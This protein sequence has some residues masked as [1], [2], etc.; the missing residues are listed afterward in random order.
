M[1]VGLYTSFDRLK[2]MWARLRRACRVSDAG[3]AEL[4]GGVNILEHY[5]TSAPDPQNALDIFAG[6]WSSKFPEPLADLRA[7]SALLFAD[8]RIEWSL[9]Q[10]GGVQGKT[11]LELG[12][13]EGGHTYMLE[14]RG[15]ASIVAIEANR[16]AY[17]KCLIVKELLDLRRARFLCG[18]FVEYLRSNSTRFDVCVASGILY[19]LRNPVELI[20]LAE[21]ASDRLYIWTH[22]YDRTLISS[23]P[24]L[25]YKFTNS[26]SAEFA[27]FR[28]T[29][30]RQEYRAALDQ[31]KFCGGSASYSHWLTRDD[32]LAG[33][34]HFGFRDIRINF[35]AP[36]HPNGPSFALTAVRSSVP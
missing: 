15:A 18:D 23:N 30:Y 17:L 14:R 29:L 4:R 20:A 12:P 7:G 1:F 16:R 28:H 10:L 32:I 21:R 6:E 13:L 26:L 35:E 22:Y 27:G 3:R 8:A 24:A 2:S 34:T 31:M 5:V 36:D 19:H 11:V 33:L 9:E 25:A